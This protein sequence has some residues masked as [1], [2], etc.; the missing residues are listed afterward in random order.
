MMATNST[1]LS[2]CAHNTNP[3]RPLFTENPRTHIWKFC[4]LLLYFFNDIF[5]SSYFII[6]FF[7]NSVIS[8]YFLAYYILL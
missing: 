3:Q 4:V 7:G 5:Y 8:E 1:P 6:F 2:A